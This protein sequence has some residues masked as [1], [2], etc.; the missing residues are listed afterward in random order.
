MISQIEFVYNY[1][2]FRHIQFQTPRY[3]GL[4]PNRKLN[5]S[6][7]D[8]FLHST[9]IRHQQNVNILN[10]VVAI[11]YHLTSSNGCHI[12]ITSNRN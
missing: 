4:T 6:S 7:G 12:G 1:V 8:D 3:N 5:I 2:I 10:Y 9:N 11:S